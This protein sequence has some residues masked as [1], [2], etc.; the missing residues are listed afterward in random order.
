MLVHF[1]Y[2]MLDYYIDRNIKI[3]MVIFIF[4]Y[5]NNVVYIL[6]LWLHSYNIIVAAI[7]YFIGL[8]YFYASV[9]LYPY[10]LIL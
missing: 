4:L 7:V 10:T 5:N 3:P 9:R 2:V 1:Y 8:L 6:F